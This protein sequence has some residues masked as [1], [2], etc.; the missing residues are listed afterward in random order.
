MSA[1]PACPAAAFAVAAP[2]ARVAACGAAAAARVA[3]ALVAA[4]LL[5]GGGA[6]AQEA[7]QRVEVSAQPLSDTEQRRREPV[8]KAIYGRDELD[9]HG[10]AS[11]SDVLKRLP[12]V[13][14]QGGSPRLRGLG[15]GYTLILVNGDPAPP[16]FSLDNLSPSQVERIEVTK[17]PTAEHPAVAGTI[18]VV[19][20]EAPRQ[21]QR[22]L[23]LNLGYQA[24]RPAVAANANWGDRDGALSYVL[25][26]SVYQWHGRVA[27]ASERLSRDG[28][29]TVQQLQVAGLD[30]WWGNGFNA[31]PRL[32]W[33]LGEAD[34]L[35]LPLFVQRHNFN[36]QG[37]FDTTVAQGAPPSSVH[38]SYRSGGYWQMARLAPQWLHRSADGGRLEVK[39]LLQAS[40]NRSYNHT[41]GLDGGGA[42]A[43][44]RDTSQHNLERQASS[45]GKYT[46]PLGESHTL[47]LG[48][49]IDR[50]WR[51]EQRSVV[52]NGVQTLAGADAQPFEV[53]VQR[54][55]VYLQDEWELAPRWSTYLGLRAEAVATRSVAVNAAVAGAAGSDSA[56][57]RNHASV[58]A[59]VW[60]LNHKLDAAG[61]DLLRASLSRSFKPP[62]LGQLV[63]RY[64]L[65]TLYAR[66]VANTPIAADRAG[67]PAL[68]PELASGLDLAFEH[69]LADGGIASIGLFHRR[70]SGL[71]R[72]QL[73]LQAVP[74]ADVA[75]WVSRPVNL[76][77]ARST[78]I[79]LEIKGRAD[80]LL[81]AALQPSPALQLRAA[82]SVYHSV[83][84]GLPGPDARLDSQQPWSASLGVDHA[85]G[86][87]WAGVP[88]SVGASLALTPAYSTQQTALQR[89]WQGGVQTLDAHALWTIR[90]DLQLRLSASNLSPRAAR[91]LTTVAEAA[92]FSARNTVSRDSL[93]SVN[94]NLLMTF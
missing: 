83:V 23:R 40:G 89:Q 46:L 33:K 60:H 10:D 19:L 64:N 27:N 70:I 15:N 75:R 42:L 13:S 41:I 34:A 71:I 86:P 37:R 36:N 43:I 73:V 35:N 45:G 38:D 20:R 9:K 88:L 94:A 74:Q 67:N 30:E 11:V 24:L 28:T 81:P 78:G 61:K 51:H 47:A 12:G 57:Q 16:G 52:E 25:P 21:R 32:S 59:P 87:Q 18:N 91:S 63:G 65:N 62:E 80:V 82:L 50:R 14:L 5:A 8:A 85:L 7:A 22:E 29:G 69:Y 72:Q 58:L 79:E 3:A 17:G 66:D 49:D 53:S 6:A 39:A 1:D 48:W 92:D 2:V 93:R 26:L 4:L 31:G 68:K 90:R 84:D 56:S 54:S 55:A 77:G 76:A 44:V